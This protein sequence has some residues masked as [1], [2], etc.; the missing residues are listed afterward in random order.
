MDHQEVGVPQE[1]GQGHEGDLLAGD[2]TICTYKQYK[3]RER[4]RKGERER[5]R[6]TTVHNM[7]QIAQIEIKMKTVSKCKMKYNNKN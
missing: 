2:Y 7:Y 3:E 4:E 5:E 6:F 1:A